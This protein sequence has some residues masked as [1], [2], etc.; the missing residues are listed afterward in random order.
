VPVYG[1]AGHGEAVCPL[2]YV[3]AL[4]G[5]R[6]RRG[7]RVAVVLDDEDTRQVPRA[8][9]VEAFEERALV[10]ASVAGERDAHLPGAADLGGEPDAADQRRTAADDAV[11]AEHALV[12]VGYVHG[13]A[14]APTDA[15]I[16]AV[17]LQHHP[18]DVAALGDGV[19][20]TPMCAGHVVVLVEVGH[21]PG[22]DGLLSGVE[23]HE[24]RDLTRGEFGVQPLLELPDGLHDPI[25]FE[26]L[27]LAQLARP[28]DLRHGASFLRRFPKQQITI[29]GPN[30][31]VKR[32]MLP[33]LAPGRESC[34]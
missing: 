18:L 6:L 29:D 32:E 27:F 31:R 28:R 13:A 30:I 1:D 11:R 2:G 5:E 8:R 7:L 14:L 19:A 3:Y 9:Q 24:A 22:R 16:L 17:D 20:V 26:Q 33:G 23:V 34:R 10:G 25:H 4:A 12:E 15:L 21:K